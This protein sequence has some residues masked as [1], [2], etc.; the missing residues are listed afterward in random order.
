MTGKILEI[1][2]A[3]KPIYTIVLDK[4]IKAKEGQPC[5]LKTFKPGRTI[6]QNKF[7]WAF[8]QWLIAPTGGNLREQ[9][10]FSAD[11]LHQDLKS[12]YQETYQADLSGIDFST[13]DLGIME[14][15]EYFMRVELNLVNQFFG[16]DTSQFHIDYNNF[17]Q[18]ASVN[19]GGTFRDYLYS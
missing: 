7:Y 1:K 9:G 12:W 16:V 4:E 3:Y 18:W 11:A 14:F 6:Q 17:C 2:K 5:E 13:A 8:L 10:H 15:S 19:D